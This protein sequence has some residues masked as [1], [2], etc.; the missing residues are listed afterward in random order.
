MFFSRKKKNIRGH[1]LSGR[2]KF[3][4]PIMLE[5]LEDRR[6]LSVTLG[7]PTASS[8]LFGQTESIA[9]TVTEGSTAV[10]PP[11]GTPVVLVNVGAVTASTNAAAI[12]A[13]GMTDS[14]GYVSFDLSKLNVGSYNLAA[15]FVD[16]NGVWETSLQTGS[17]VP[18][19]VGQ[20]STTVSL[21]SS[22]DGAAS[23]PAG[24]PVVFKAMVQVVSPGGGIPAGFVTFEDTSTGTLLGKAFV[25]L[26]PKT[27]V[28]NTGVA[29]FVDASLS[30][31]THTI[32]ATYQGNHNYLPSDPSAADLVTIQRIGDQYPGVCQPE[33][34]G[35]WR[36]R[37]HHGHGLSRFLR[38][39][40]KCHFERQAGRQSGLAAHFQWPN[41]QRRVPG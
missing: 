3:G 21:T 8:W 20:A 9:A 19:S 7:S 18:V 41:R 16:S 2:S 28:A 30:V 5:I 32:V 11:P 29:S 36:G 12:L 25:T 4:R 15:E 34:G 1:R 35:L 10:A 33:P 37:D 6:L 23:V 31:G 27:T 22:A 24:Q 26:T 17:A 40:A 14:N 38:P 39:G 13:K